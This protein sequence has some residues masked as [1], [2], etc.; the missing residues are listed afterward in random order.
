MVMFRSEASGRF[1]PSRTGAWWPRPARRPRV[2]GTYV[3]LDYFSL[4]RDGLARLSDADLY[5][6]QSRWKPGSRL[7]ALGEV[8]RRRREGGEPVAGTSVPWAFLAGSAG[9]I[10]AAAML[11]V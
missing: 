7:H 2:S 11:L 6:W 8:E 10:G 3:P 1:Q 9:L 4:E 5:L